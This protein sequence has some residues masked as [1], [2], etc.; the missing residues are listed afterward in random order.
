M[1]PSID[2][3]SAMIGRKVPDGRHS[4]PLEMMETWTT[5]QLCR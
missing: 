5:G 2:Y 3:R 1:T 4:P